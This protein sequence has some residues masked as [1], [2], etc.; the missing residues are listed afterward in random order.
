MEE[1]DHDLREDTAV[2]QDE[3]HV[4]DDLLDYAG[5]RVSRDLEDVLVWPVLPPVL[6]FDQSVREPAG[7]DQ[8]G[9]ERA[10][11]RNVAH[12]GHPQDRITVVLDQPLATFVV[13]V[14]PTS[15][16]SPVFRPVDSMPDEPGSCE[17]NGAGC[18]GRLPGSSRCETV[19]L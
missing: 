7:L 15:T 4:V 14:H 8:F 3:D 6:D 9:L 2:E 19:A 12:P 18:E 10:P 16:S 5:L 17:K 1:K 11:G 13:L